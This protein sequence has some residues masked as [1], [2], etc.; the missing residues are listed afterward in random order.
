MRATR[1]VRLPDDSLIDPG[2]VV[3]LSLEVLSPWSFVPAG[4]GNPGRYGAGVVIRFRD[5]REGHLAYDC[6]DRAWEALGTIADMI[7]GC[8]S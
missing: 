5:G 6:K 8:A 1:L 4:P 3:K 7:N 2:D